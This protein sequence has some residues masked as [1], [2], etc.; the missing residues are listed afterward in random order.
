MKAKKIL[1]LS[2]FFIMGLI[3]CT[4]NVVNADTTISEVIVDFDGAVP[5]VG[6]AP[7]DVVINSEKYEVV[8]QEWVECDEDGN[9]TTNK[10]ATFEYGKT[11]HF[12]IYVRVK[13]GYASFI[14]NAP[15][16]TI[17]NINGYNEHKAIVTNED[18]RYYG[19]VNVGLDYTTGTVHDDIEIEGTEDIIPVVGGDL[20]YLTIT[21]DEYEVEYQKWLDESFNPVSTFEE[22][23]EYYY[24]LALKHKT[25]FGW[26]SSSTLN[27][28]NIDWIYTMTG[29]VVNEGTLVFAGIISPVEKDDT[30]TKIDFIGDVENQEFIKGTD[31][32]LEFVIKSPREYG[33][34]FVDGVELSSDNGD[35]DWLFLESYP[36]IALSGEYLNTL[37]SG[38]YTVKFVLDGIGEAETTFTIVGQDEEEKIEEEL[39][40][41]QTGDNTIAYISTLIISILGI[42]LVVNKKLNKSQ[43]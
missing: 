8:F 14:D 43:E 2:L 12:E 26:D 37:K 31:T 9:S 4:P 39:N 27:V 7:K 30:V 25:A 20:P 15:I 19:C 6:E 17:K 16:I 34:V 33:K 42:S 3:L 29:P 5:V 24:V 36:Y 35:Y 11:Y 40:N 41:P 23:K 1:F 22:G 32:K 18:N 21:S 28:S 10:V 38:T 13:E